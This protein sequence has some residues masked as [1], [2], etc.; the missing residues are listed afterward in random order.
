[1]IPELYLHGLATG[2]FELSLRSFL[3]EGASLSPS[4][5]TLLKQRW[6]SEYESWRKRSLS[7]DSYAYLWCD[8]V[9]P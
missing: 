4:S 6:E 7:W 9:Y 3:G 8:G 2:D 5:V 1:M